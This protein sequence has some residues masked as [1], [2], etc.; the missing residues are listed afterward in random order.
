MHQHRFVR[1]RGDIDGDVLNGQPFPRRNRDGE[2]RGREAVL[3]VKL[4]DC[5]VFIDVKGFK[6]GAFTSNTGAGAAAAAVMLCCG[7][8]GVLFLL[9]VPAGDGAPPANS[10]GQTGQLGPPPFQTSL[11]TKGSLRK[12]GPTWPKGQPGGY[13]LFAHFRRTPPMPTSSPPSSSSAKLDGSGAP[14]AAA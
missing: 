7:C 14:E 12:F 6:A 11:T 1:L 8:I 10:F 4:L 2:N 3:E 5:A 9:N 13:R